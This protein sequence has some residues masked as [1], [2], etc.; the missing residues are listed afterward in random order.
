M[1]FRHGAVFYL[2]GIRKVM[3]IWD[4]F[5]HKFISVSCKQFCVD[6][7]WALLKQTPN[8][9]IPQQIRIQRTWSQSYVL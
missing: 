7:S 6:K 8:K 3:S 1:Q 4:N 9:V 5:D 2:K